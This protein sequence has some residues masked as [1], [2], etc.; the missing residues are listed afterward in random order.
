MSELN[1][2]NISNHSKEE[3]KINQTNDE[4]TQKIFELELIIKEKEEIINTLYSKI[5]EFNL[6]IEQLKIENEQLK[7]QLM[8]IEKEIKK[9]KSIF[10]DNLKMQQTQR[11]KVYKNITNISNNILG[12]HYISNNNLE[13]LDNNFLHQNINDLYFNDNSFYNND[14]DNDNINIDFINQSFKSKLIPFQMKPFQT[15]DHKK[16]DTKYNSSIIND[17]KDES[18]VFTNQKSIN[19]N[20]NDN[21]CSCC[22]KKMDENILNIKE[23]YNK[24]NKNTNNSN[25]INYNKK[26]E[27]IKLHSSMFFQNCKK[28]INKNEYKKLLEI[29]KLSNLKKISKEDT[30]LKITSLLDNNYPEL[31][32]QFKLLFI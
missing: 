5:K 3:E 23:D 11:F 6:N 29:V 4:F 24:K 21:L 13:N 25:N 9:N 28:V 20:T 15:F 22:L 1:N 31:S 27:G 18:I 30:Y 2:L 19:K 8:F 32:N 12:S 14:N 16:L 17:I 10:N 26:K 7:S